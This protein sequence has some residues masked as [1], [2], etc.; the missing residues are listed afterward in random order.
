M[1]TF[2]SAE[3]EVGRDRA[4]KV[5]AQRSGPD[6]E[7]ERERDQVQFINVSTPVSVCQPR[8]MVAVDIGMTVCFFFR[9]VREV[10]RLS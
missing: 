7:I 2:P 3:I 6:R 4:P 1:C 8:A 10:S 9:G 5:P